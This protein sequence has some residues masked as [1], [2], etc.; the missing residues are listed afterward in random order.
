MNQMIF[1]IFKSGNLFLVELYTKTQSNFYL[2]REC[3]YFMTEAEAKKW[4]MIKR[5]QE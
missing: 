3:K 1:E 4:I 5:L 2:T